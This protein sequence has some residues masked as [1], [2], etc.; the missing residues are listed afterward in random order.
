VSTDDGQDC[1]SSRVRVDNSCGRA[2]LVS[3]PTRHLGASKTINF[4]IQN[5]T[6]LSTTKCRV[7]AGN[8]CIDCN[9]KREYVCLATDMGAVTKVSWAPHRNTPYHPRRI[10]RRRDFDIHDNRH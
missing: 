5:H 1:V 4:I 2:I 8:S 6:L 7:G 3:A 9:K 10:F